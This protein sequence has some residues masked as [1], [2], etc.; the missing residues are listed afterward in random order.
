MNKK[1]LITFLTVL[2]FFLASGVQ[3]QV[4]KAE[5][6]IN[7][8]TCSQ[9]SKSVYN[10][11]KKLDFIKEVDMD[12]YETIAHIEFLPGK[13]IEFE[14]IQQAVKNAGFSLRNIIVD[15]Q[16]QLENQQKENTICFQNNCFL[17][18]QVWESGQ[19]LRLELIGSKINADKKLN[20]QVQS[21]P[22]LPK[23]GKNKWYHS[24]VRE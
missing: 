4:L 3:A 19:P 18:D 23:D 13:K 24:L 1:S 8:L 22:D 6:G 20:K 21:M 5:I 16:P 9:C 11:I 2:F 17:L 7:G 12:L 14:A 15:V 10:S